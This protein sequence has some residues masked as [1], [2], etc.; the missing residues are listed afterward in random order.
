MKKKSPFIVNFIL[1]T[2]G[3]L[4][5]AIL[6]IAV[7]PLLPYPP[8][9]NSTVVNFDAL[10]VGVGM[11]EVDG[12]LQIQNSGKFVANHN[13]PGEFTTDENGYLLPLRFGFD[14]FS[15]NAGIHSIGHYLGLRGRTGQSEGL[16]GR[17]GV[18]GRIIAPQ[19]ALA[20]LSTVRGF[21]G[22]LEHD[23]SLSPTVENDIDLSNPLFTTSPSSSLLD[24]YVRISKGIPWA[25]YTENESKFNDDVQLTGNL[26]ADPG[27]LTFGPNNGTALNINSNGDLIADTITAADFEIRDDLE[28]QFSIVSA[29]KPFNHSSTVDNQVFS[30]NVYC[31]SGSIRLG[32]SGGVVVDTYAPAYTPYIGATQVSNNPLG[33]TSYAR[34]PPGNVPGNLN[35]YAY[36]WN[37]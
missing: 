34:K 28:S 25:F 26:V 16:F 32:C 17:V 14:V 7:T 22:Y 35:V 27:P 6:A 10:N 21:A 4:G 37:P 29:A 1:I 31:P 9:V 11:P 24:D 3:V 2:I 20:G 5:G 15:D 33:C 30:K 12:T 8:S 36:C 18:E 19:Q 23:P 13:I